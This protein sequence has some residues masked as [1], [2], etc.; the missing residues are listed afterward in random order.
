VFYLPY[1]PE[2]ITADML[3]QTAVATV[4]NPFSEHM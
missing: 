2:A 1:D 3:G 4:S